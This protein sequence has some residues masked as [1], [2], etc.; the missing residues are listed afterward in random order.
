[1]QRC[2]FLAIKVVC[3]WTDRPPAVAKLGCGQSVS[4]LSVA[5]ASAAEF[6]QGG[7]KQVAAASNGKSADDMTTLGPPRLGVAVPV[8]PDGKQQSTGSATGNPR[9]KVALQPGRSL[10]DWIRLGKSGTDLTGVGGRLMDVTTEELA[11]HCTVNDAW[12]A[13]KGQCIRDGKLGIQ[14][15]C[16]WV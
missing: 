5:P 8:R 16:C 7:R 4:S 3:L 10:L 2:R 6:G 14:C 1:M 15:C 12:T 13:L 11:K 9:N